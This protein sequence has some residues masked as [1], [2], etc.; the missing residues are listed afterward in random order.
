MAEGLVNSWSH[1]NRFR[2]NNHMNSYEKTEIFLYSDS[3][4]M[5]VNENVNHSDHVNYFGGRTTY[6]GKWSEAGPDIN[7]FVIQICKKTY[8]ENHAIC[9]KEENVQGSIEAIVSSAGLTILKSSFWLC[10]GILDNQITRLPPRHVASAEMDKVQIW[11]HENLFN[12]KNVIRSRELTEISFH[13]DHSLVIINENSGDD[14]RDDNNGDERACH[15]IGGKTTYI[16]T[17][18]TLSMDDDKASKQTRF[19][20]YL[21]EKRFEQNRP[22][23]DAEYSASQEE[24]TGNIEAIV[25][26][27]N[28]LRILTSSEWLSFGELDNA[29]R[30]EP[31]RHLP[32]NLFL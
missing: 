1:E 14:Q 10:F 16:G 4:A 29:V 28:H 8:Q 18:H 9:G 13:P 6:E 22:P 30:H 21:T 2:D 27:H 12:E 23:R 11:R 17:W 15:F 32:G 25:D 26:E 20:I 19:V 31:P 5:I 7:R 3:S 24:I